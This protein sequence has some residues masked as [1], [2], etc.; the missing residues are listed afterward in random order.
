MC[1]YFE[2]F[3]DAI[4]SIAPQ[5]NGGCKACVG[6]H[7]FSDCPWSQTRCINPK[8]NS[9]KVGILNIS[10]TSWNYG[11]GYLKCLEC[12]DFQWVSDAIFMKK[13]KQLD[14]IEDQICA[15]LKIKCTIR[16]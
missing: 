16:R 14:N 4:K 5:Y 15:Q 6:D 10:Q 1:S 8:C 12:E 2:W 3:D 7:K 13:Q 9:T 11:I